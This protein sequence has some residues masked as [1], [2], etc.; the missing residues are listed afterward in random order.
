MNTSIKNLYIVNISHI[1]NFFSKYFNQAQQITQ[2]KQQVQE[3]EQYKVLYALNTNN[4]SDDVN[5]SSINKLDVISYM[6]FNDFSKVLLKSD[7][8][9]TEEIKPLITSNGFSAGIA[10]KTDNEL[11][12]YLNHNEKCNYAV[13]IGKELVP[14]ITSGNERKEN[15][16]V[17]YI[18]I[19]QKVNVGDEVITS[20]MDNI[21]SKGIKV[22]KVLKVKSLASTQVA[23]IK[24]YANVHSKEYFYTTNDVNTSK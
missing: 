19:W 2:L 8:I 18:P 17:K 15:I 22:G 16:T 23:T 12:G 14:G 21:F 20:G 5:N 11:V 1:E 6:N 24:P 7:H 3:G 4:V 9:L 10:I 13:F